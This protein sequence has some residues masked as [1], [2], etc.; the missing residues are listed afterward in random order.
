LGVRVVGNFVEGETGVRMRRRKREES[1][2]RSK[3][4]AVHDDVRQLK[5]E[6]RGLW[7]TDMP[8]RTLSDLSAEWLPRKLAKISAPE[9]F[10]GRVRLH[11]LPALGQHTHATLLPRDIEDLLAAMTRDGYGPQTVNHVRDAGRQLINYATANR[12]WL[13]GNPFDLVGKLKIPDEEKDVLSAREAALLLRFVSRPRRPIFALALF[14]GPR[15]KTMFHMRPSDVDLPGLLVD[16]NVVKGG[17]KIRS[18]PIPEELAPYMQQALAEARGE[19]LFSQDDGRQ[20][21]RTSHV[22]N[23]E[24]AAAFE[25][26]GVRR[27]TSAPDIT[28]HGL[29]RCS[30]TLHQEEGCHAWVVSKIL[31][32]SQKSLQDFGNL[33]ENMTG[34]RYT[35]FSTQFIRRE[36]NRLS[37][38]PIKTL[39]ESEP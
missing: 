33:V 11:L 39:Q 15:R 1:E 23:D 13:G 35:Q 5:M 24:L 9:T 21:C 7:K 4:D 18:V 27:G 38:K 6:L 8:T 28:F 25:R 29:R 34:K 10:E 16:F 32:H 3:V 22:L 36:L 14:L 20:M 37:L 19:W 12:A 30:S 2:L 17:K 31:G 26:A